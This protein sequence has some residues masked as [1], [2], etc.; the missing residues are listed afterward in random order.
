MC[1]VQR[2]DLTIKQ[3]ELSIKSTYHQHYNK[4]YDLWLA[5]FNVDQWRSVSFFRTHPLRNGGSKICIVRLG[6]WQISKSKFFSKIH[7]PINQKWGLP[8]KQKR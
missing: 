4:Y 1:G 7:F 8:H 2:F 5:K 6:V 3:A